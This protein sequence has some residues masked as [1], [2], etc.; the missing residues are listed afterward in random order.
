MRRCVGALA[1]VVGCGC[2]TAAG[3]AER[4]FERSEAQR[5]ELR[6]LDVVVVSA[7]P[8]RIAEERFNVR[9]F[10]PP[11]ADAPLVVGPEDPAT[12]DA[13][14]QSVRDE[15][16]RRGFTVRLFHSAAGVPGAARSATVAR[17]RTATAT[18]ARTSSMTPAESGT[19]DESVTPAEADALLGT[20]T[21][22][23]SLLGSSQAD[24]VL[25]V[26]AVPVD[27]FTLDYG[28][29][30]YVQNTALGRQKVRDYQPVR[31]RGRLLVGQAFLFDRRTGLRLWT[32]QAPDYPD[33]GRLEPGHPF[34]R[35]GVVLA[36]GQVLEGGALAAAATQQFVPRILDGLPSPK[37]G[38]PDAR[39]A[40][41]AMDPS[42]ETAR[43]SFLD[44][45][46]VV[47]DVSA[48]YALETM[49]MELS[50]HEQPLDALGPGA[51]APGGLLRL[52]PRLGYLG[53]GGT[54]FSLGVPVTYASAG[55][56]RTY[57]QEN[58]SPTAG[59]PDARAVHVV[60]G[61]ILSGGIEL[62]IGTLI[63]LG[64][65]LSL[66]PRGGLFGDVWSIDAGPAETVPKGARVRAGGLLGA[67][68]WMRG[69]RLFGRLGLDGRLGADFEGAAA[70]GLSLSLGFGLLL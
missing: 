69:E 50:F 68:V 7:G 22:L 15:L 4:S 57:F 16:A 43:Q 53:A 46:H 38:D 28:K 20:E 18:K 47:V 67:D 14:V 41:D 58:P 44:V 61:G 32:R 62:Q 33:E 10:E 56:G 63:H 31:R 37:A 64:G 29:G 8:P 9:G 17:A 59:D 2:A 11:E 13:L 36:E 52:T 25:V 70:A 5:V 3:V 45:G 35:S 51:L 40:L 19:H 6:T 55:F 1:L 21:T 39:A 12:R 27:E 42:A 48:G 30:V 54:L 26:R 65:D 34:L 24:A 66:V 49:S 60:A 23:A